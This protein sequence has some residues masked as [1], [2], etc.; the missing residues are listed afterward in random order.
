MPDTSVHSGAIQRLVSGSSYATVYLFRRTPATVP[1]GMASAA[2]QQELADSAAVMAMRVAAETGARNMPRP[3]GVSGNRGGMEDLRCAAI[4]VPVPQGMQGDV[5][6]VGGT[7]GRLLKLRLTFAIPGK[8]LQQ[9]A[10]TI[11]AGTMALALAYEVR[12]RI[13]GAPSGLRT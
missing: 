7:L 10:A 2:A 8:E 1:D 9:P 4:A 13:G 5:V 3:I 12:S 11:L 6:C